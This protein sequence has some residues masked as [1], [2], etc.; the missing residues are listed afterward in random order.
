MSNCFVLIK[1]S[2]FFFSLHFLFPFDFLFFLLHFIFYLHTFLF[3]FEINDIFNLLLIEIASFEVLFLS[4][5][6]ILQV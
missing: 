5:C 4:E 3:L 6:Q 2:F 1:I